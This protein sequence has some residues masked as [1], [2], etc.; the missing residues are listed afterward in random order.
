MF[1][2]YDLN[3]LAAICGIIWAIIVAISISTTGKRFYKQSVARDWKK[4]T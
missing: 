3:Y 2:L 1:L 4:E